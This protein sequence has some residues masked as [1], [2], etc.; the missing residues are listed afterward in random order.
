MATTTPSSGN[1]GDPG[2]RGA[3]SP[4]A[5]RPQ[6]GQAFAGP[7]SVRWTALHDAAGVVAGLGGVACEPMAAP[8]RNFPAAMRD[9]G[10]WRRD[11]AEQGVQDLA[12]IMAPGLAALLAVRARG[13]DAVPAA[14]ALWE[15]FRRARDTLLAL[16]P[17][18]GPLRAA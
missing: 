5:S 18:S 17:P 3:P 7:L 10:G 6:F 15:E 1:A 13:A 14:L 9:A 16:A 11:L 2:T 4:G 8:L 12:A